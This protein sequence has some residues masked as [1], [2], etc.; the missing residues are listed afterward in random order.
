VVDSYSEEG[1]LLV[2]GRNGFRAWTELLTRQLVAVRVPRLKA[3]SLAIT[4]LASVEGS[5][6]LC[7]AERS[8]EP[9]EQV[10]E[11]LRQAASAAAKKR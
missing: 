7:R 9:L 1:E 11:Q 8:V 3:R 6:I 4:T 5:L 10:A 2:L